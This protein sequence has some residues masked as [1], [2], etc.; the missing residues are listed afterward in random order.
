[1]YI[2]GHNPAEFAQ[3]PVSAPRTPAATRLAADLLVNI[4]DHHRRQVTLIQCIEQVRYIQFLA[5][6]NDQIDSWNLRTGLG[7]HFG[8]ATRDNHPG[9]PVLPYGATHLLTRLAVCFG[10]NRTGI[11]DIQVSVLPWAHSAP[12]IAG[13]F[14]SDEF[15]LEEIDLASQG[16][17]RNPS[18]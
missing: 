3:T 15:G 18:G 11:D 5:V 13:H 12:G 1:M 8:I 6:S 10:C 4:P 17:K 2:P 9:I 7:I 16:G 14:F